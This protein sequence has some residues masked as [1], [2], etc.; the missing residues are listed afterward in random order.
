MLVMTLAGIATGIVTGMVLE[1]A[2]SGPAIAIAAGLVAAIASVFARHMVVVRNGLPGPDHS[3]LTS[4]TI[5]F[6]LVAALAGGLAAEEVTDHLLH[7]PHKLV[8]GFAGLFSAM[9]M[10]ILLTAYHMNPDK[11]GNRILT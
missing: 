11:K 8:G 1:G 9:L 7:L 4:I 5:V 3:S 2:M 6:S 10:A